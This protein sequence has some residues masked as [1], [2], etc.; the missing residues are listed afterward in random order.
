MATVTYKAANGQPGKAWVVSLIK[1]DVG[2]VFA[3]AAPSAS[4]EAQRPTLVKVLSSFGFDVAASAGAIAHS[5]SSLSNLR[6]VKWVDPKEQAFTAQVPAG[7]KVEGGMFRFSPTDARASCYLRSPDGQIAIR[8]GDVT[9]PCFKMPNDLDASFGKREGQQVGIGAG[10]LGILLRYLPAQDFNQWYAANRLSQAVSNLQLS[11]PEDMPEF[12]RKVDATTKA[13]NFTG[14]RPPALVTAARVSFTGTSEG[15]PVSGVIVSWTT[16][17]G[18][19]WTGHPNVCFLSPAANPQA[20]QQAFAS[21]LDHLV[22][23]GTPNPE[24]RDRQARV[25][26]QKVA[27]QAEVGNQ[28]MRLQAERFAAWSRE[29]ARQNQELMNSMHAQTEARLAKD[30]ARHASVGQFN[31]AMEPAIPGRFRTIA[32][33]GRTWSTTRATSASARRSCTTT[34]LKTARWSIP[35]ASW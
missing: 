14:D 7:W 32:W 8:S 30:E 12:A 26:F 31:A 18:A 28:F 29:S 9:V 25:V 21:I 24:W 6:F 5:S 34:R 16:R 3:M 22:F 33:I 17:S 20:A 19:I 1:P 23:Q 2:Y 13:S 27:E 11:N 35:T 4:L 15:K 10:L